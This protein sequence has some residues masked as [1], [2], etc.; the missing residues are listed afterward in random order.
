MAGNVYNPQVGFSLIGNLANP[1]KYPYN[2]FYGEWSPRLAAAWD[3]FGDGRTVIRGGYGRTYGRL[4]GVDQV[5]VPLLGQGLIQAVSCTNALATG[6]CGGTGSATASTAFRVG[7]D[8]LTAPL[9]Q[10]S[11]TLPQPSFP[12]VNG[13]AAGAAEAQDPNFRP[14][15]VDSFTLT[16]QR[17]L[18]NKVSMEVGYIGRIINNEYLPINLN[19]V[20]Y[21]IT[22]GG[23]TFAKAYA[24]AVIG[25]CGN[26]NVNNLGGGQCA[27]NAGR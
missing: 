23:Q 4:N 1:Q 26:G 12:G 25:Y 9:P 2:P 7:V 15:V 19:A 21:N 10:A 18:T 17:Q 11:P 27:G 13:P 8:G 22:K 16:F 14:N 6:T 5:L 20:P 3:V 24:N